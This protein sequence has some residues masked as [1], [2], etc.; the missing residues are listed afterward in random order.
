MLL[1]LTQPTASGGTG[2]HSPVYHLLGT[3]LRRTPSETL[4]PLLTDPSQ[5]L[6]SPTLPTLLLFECVLVYMTPASS[7]DILRWFTDYFSAP[8]AEASRSVLGCI[9]YEMFGL[10]DSFGKVMVNNLRVSHS[11]DTFSFL[12]TLTGHDSRRGTSPCPARSPTP[13]WNRSRAAS[14]STGGRLRGR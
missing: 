11:P 13:R 14:R 8:A 1:G 6:L 4:A 5:P 10:E 12:N 2:V 7:N 9:V 3:D